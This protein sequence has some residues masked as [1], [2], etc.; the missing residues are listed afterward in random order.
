[1]KTVICKYTVGTFVNGLSISGN[2][3]GMNMVSSGLIMK[4]TG[5][6]VDNA[7]TNKFKFTISFEPFEKCKRV[8]FNQQL[9]LLDLTDYSCVYTGVKKSGRSKFICAKYLKKFLG[10][11]P[12]HKE[13]IY[14]KLELV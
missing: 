10:R 12:E 6:N 14:Y 8:F 4:R 7:R 5:I 1:M 9:T 3:S 2:Y 11:L 13:A